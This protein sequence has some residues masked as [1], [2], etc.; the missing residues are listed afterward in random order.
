MNIARVLRIFGLSFGI[1]ALI[2]V[3]IVSFLVGFMNS[4]VV[5]SA[6]SYVLIN[7]L[8]FFVAIISVLILIWMLVKE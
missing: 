4:S 8:E 5:I 7:Q 6:D 3:A 2:M 1:S